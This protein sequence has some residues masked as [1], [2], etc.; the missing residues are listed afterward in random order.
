MKTLFA[1]AAAAAMLLMAGEPHPLAAQA[2]RCVVVPARPGK[3]WRE[4]KIR[5]TKSCP[6]EG[7]RRKKPKAQRAA[8]KITRHA[9]RA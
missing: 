5:M 9:A 3:G 6:T 2:D 4:P 1:S 7:E 8:R